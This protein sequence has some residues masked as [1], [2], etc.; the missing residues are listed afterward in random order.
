MLLRGRHWIDP[1]I[2]GALIAVALSLTP[3][4]P[5]ARA[6]HGPP[7]TSFDEMF[8]PQS[9]TEP[10]MTSEAT[11]ANDPR[12]VYVVVVDGLRP[13]DVG[14]ATPRLRELKD[15]GTWYEQAR[16]VYPAETLPN[17]A[18]MATGVLPQRNG[19]IANQFFDSATGTGR[20]YMQHPAFLESDTIVTRLERAF[21]TRGGI[22]TATVLSKLYLFGLFRGEYDGAPDP[23]PQREADF[24]WNPRS[25]GARYVL[26][27][28]DHALDQ[29]SMEAFLG[30][31]QS[32]RDSP[33]PQF[34][35]L[36]LGDVDRSGHID[37][38]GASL[39]EGA[40]SVARQAAL[41]DTDTQVGLLIDE[42]KSSGAWAHSAVILLSDHGMDW[43]LPDKFADITGKLQ[44]K[45]GT[46]STDPD[47]SDYWQVGGG[48]S[49]LVYVHNQHNI[50]PIAQ[51]VSSVEGVDFVATRERI[52]D[53]LSPNVTF[54]E[55]GIDHP[56]TPAIQ[57]FMEHGWRSSPDAAGHNNPLP[58]NHGHAV[59]QHSTL[60]VAGGDPR[61][62][63]GAG[64]AV[65]GT[66]VYDPNRATLFVDPKAG[67]GVL[68]VAPTVAG[69]FGLDAP[70]GGYDDAPLAAAFDP[71]TFSTS[72][73]G[74]T[75]PGA[76][77]G[78]GPG[79]VAPMSSAG[80]LVTT[81]RSTR[82]RARYL[83]PFGL[84]G[85]VTAASVCGAARRV[86][87]YAGPLGRPA[88]AR[89]IATPAVGA[90]G[91][92]SL[93]T[94]SETT[95]AYFARVQ[96]TPGCSGE[97]SSPV[98]VAVHGRIAG[99]KSCQ[100]TPRIRGRVLPRAPGSRVDLLQRRGRRYRRVASRRLGAGSSFVFPIASCAGRY[101][102][103]W[104]G[105]AGRSLPSSANVVEARG[106]R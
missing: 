100:G 6:G 7:P 90:S 60:L 23:L 1:V 63:D 66:P 48:G 83:Q 24:H 32:Q 102:V 5:S 40:I 27:P 50:A 31:V 74:S 57:A 39:P 17:H 22:S 41:E 15:S 16:A 35:W 26:N 25:A 82:G 87:V 33:L 71:G 29:A 80:G 93:P 4:V 62:R 85:R 45:Y 30:W 77:T 84:S 99:A 2:V 58:G 61:L 72:S 78:S 101:R 37:A 86:D 96:P 69:L 88:M 70:S 14:L 73:G 92:W 98:P 94:R 81:I 106:T 11:A 34:G 44:P 91:D 20:V 59:T 28:S 19:I 104:P 76:S 21:E 9:S 52:P 49:E 54:R 3:L 55:M 51:L 64:M 65:P 18:A 75:G 89:L 42:L 67:P 79:S 95:R 68:S 38:S 36:N 46:P 8:Q 43:S 105:Q 97:L 13:Q 10:T 53:M 47:T 12:R 56:K 103:S